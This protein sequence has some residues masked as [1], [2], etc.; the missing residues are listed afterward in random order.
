MIGLLSVGLLSL[1]GYLVLDSQYSE[2][3][4]AALF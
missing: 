1:A 2:Q 4:S 3:S